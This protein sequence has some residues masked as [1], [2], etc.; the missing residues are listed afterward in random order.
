[1]DWNLAKGAGPKVDKARQ[2]VAAGL[3]RWGK[4]YPKLC[5]W[6]EDNIEE[7]LTFYRLPVQH[8]KNLKSTNM[9]ERLMEEIN[10]G[11]IERALG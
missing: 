2:D 1:M 7:T 6:V 9:L 3:S 5:S 11:G 4:R 8:R 10:D